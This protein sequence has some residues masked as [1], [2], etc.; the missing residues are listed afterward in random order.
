M[1]NQEIT[2]KLTV[3]KWNVVMQGV[4]GLPFAQVA[5][6]VPE[7]KSQAEAQIRAIGMSTES[8]PS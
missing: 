1:E 4:T 7:M 8:Q 2:I 3:A 5:E 6:I